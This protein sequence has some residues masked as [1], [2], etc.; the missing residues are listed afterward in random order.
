LIS[1]LILWLLSLLP[2]L[3]MGFE[4]RFSILL[5]AVV[6][7]LINALIVPFVKRIFRKSNT[8]LLL[9]ASLVIDAAALWLV[10]FIVPGFYI[11]FFPTAIVVVVILTAINAG[12]SKNK[13][14]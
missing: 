6:L 10:G 9:I 4:R 13:S 8:L 3:D 12:F 5:V 2:F 1:A 11:A 7:G 14:R